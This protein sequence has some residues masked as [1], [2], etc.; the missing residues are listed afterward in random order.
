MTVLKGLALLLAIIATSCQASRVIRGPDLTPTPY[1]A[2]LAGRWGRIHV[3][4]DGPAAGPVVIFV[5][6]YPYSLA[7]FRLVQPLL[8]TKGIRSIALDIPGFGRSDP[9]PFPPDRI[10][11]AEQFSRVL[12]TIYDHWRVRSATLVGTNTGATLITAFADAYPD[13]VSRL[14]I[15]GPPIFTTAERAELIAK[16]RPRDI[17][18]PSKAWYA[19]EAVYKYDMIAALKRLK[20]PAMVIAYPGQVLYKA[21][22]AVKAMRPDFILRSITSTAMVASLDPSSEW[23]DAV[24]NYVVNGN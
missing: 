6:Q 8:A 23:A 16:N 19:H 2:D 18:S 1:E 5:H 24:A 4:V 17:G 3:R 7:Q 15:D 9:P 13:K 20:V 14:V 12:S 21:S 22:L 11:S 10:P